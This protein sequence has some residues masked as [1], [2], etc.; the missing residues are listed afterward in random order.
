MFAG[1]FLFI[2][3][4]LFIWESWLCPNLVQFLLILN[5][6]ITILLCFDVTVVSLLHTALTGES[7][8]R[9]LKPLMTV[10]SVT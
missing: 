1:N 10:L 7:A 8:N 9:P 5:H 6:V 3:T 2:P 4:F